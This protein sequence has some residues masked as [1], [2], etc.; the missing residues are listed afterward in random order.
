M[1]GEAGVQ[2]SDGESGPR[3]KSVSS[4]A[5]FALFLVHLFEEIMG[6]FTGKTS[7]TA[8][9]SS[10]SVTSRFCNHFWIR[11]GRLTCK[12]FTVYLGIK[13]VWAAWRWK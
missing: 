12:M 1:Q 2:G 6:S 10:E 8:R 7:T 9:T 3:G 5:E 13:L 11:P 4:V